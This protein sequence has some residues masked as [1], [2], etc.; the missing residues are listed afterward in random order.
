MK[1]LILLALFA[2]S[3]T[4]SAI[5][6]GLWSYN[7]GTCP[8]KFRY[9]SEKNDYTGKYDVYYQVQSMKKHDKYDV[10]FQIE[11]ATSSES[12]PVMAHIF[13]GDSTTSGMHSFKYA[14]SVILSCEGSEKLS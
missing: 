11:S 12:T 10:R 4:A 3:A 6:Y 2:V 8:V 14:P 9:L 1:K 7:T 13:D 5:E